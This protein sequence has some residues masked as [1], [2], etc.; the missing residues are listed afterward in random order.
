[1]CDCCSVPSDDA[2]QDAQPDM[3]FTV[4]T[5]LDESAA[6]DDCCSTNGGETLAVEVATQ[7]AVAVQHC[8]VCGKRGKKVDTQ[9]VK[10]MLSV[11]LEEIRPVSYRF[12]RTETC[13]VVYFAEDGAQVFGETALRE[14][15][16]QKHLDEDD[17]FACYCFRHT[18]GTIRE[19]IM[20]T[21]ES[22][23]VA[24]INAGIKAGQ[25]ACEVR[26]PQG[27]CCLGN[28]TATV[29]RIQAALEPMAAD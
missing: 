13:S 20:T 11:S 14:Q 23:A 7:S 8:P 29:K 6:S 9:T 18:P 5:A 3:T 28:V 17:V 16:H 27:S 12:C 25:C 2:A 26:N 19:E 22:T 21:G 24:R 10:A 4:I 1:M 15:V